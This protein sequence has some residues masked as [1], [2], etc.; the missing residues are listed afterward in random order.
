M[1][2]YN[3]ILIKLSGEALAGDDQ[4]GLNFDTVLSIC[5]AI[6]STKELG[7]EIA[8][9]VGGGNFWRGRDNL[10]M[11]RTRADHMGMLATVMNSLAIADALEKQDVPVRVMTALP[12]QQV[13]EPYIRN[14]AIR[15][16]EKG[17]VIIL[18]CGTG[19]PFFSTDTAAALRAAEIN[20]DIIFKATLV[21]GVYD[22]DPHKYPDAVKY[23][24]LSFSR[25][26]NDGL[27]VIDSTAASM[28]RDNK[29]P[30][31]VFDLKN[32]PQNMVKAVLG[33][34]IGTIIEEA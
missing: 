18:A 23:S 17:R 30:I 1:L 16:L 20:A 4:R 13:A 9:V 11:E 33:E 15:H 22:K 7:A 32:D 5:S 8:I 12:M 25:V 24:T 27:M 34:D 21:D 2:K 28:C 6:K 29:I 10:Q 14:R 26:L 19:N 3:R 31:L